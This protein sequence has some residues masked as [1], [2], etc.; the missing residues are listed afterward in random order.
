MLSSQV[1]R[2][3]RLPAVAEFLKPA[4]YVALVV[5]LLALAGALAAAALPSLFGYSPITVAGGSMGQAA[6][7]G[8]L[9]FARWIE[10]E[11]VEVGDIILV[12]GKDAEAGAPPTLHRVAWLGREGG[13]M[14]ARTQGDVNPDPDPGIYI[15]PDRVLTPAAT[16]PYLGFFVG[17]ALTPLGWALIALLPS[18]VLCALVLRSIWTDAADPAPTT[19]TET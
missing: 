18:A 11:S 6:P 9:V 3:R 7:N 12:Q 10:A 16:V 8:S 5:A 13:R 2:S 1:S 17:F 4:V 14:L 15:L 19:R